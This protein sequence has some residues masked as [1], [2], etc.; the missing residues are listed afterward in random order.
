MFSTPYCPEGNGAVERVNYTIGKLLAHLH[1]AEIDWDILLSKAVIT[2]NSTYH[3]QIKTSPS[4][5]ILAH[6]HDVPE[7]TI[8]GTIEKWT[9]GHTKYCSFK[10]H[11]LVAREKPRSGH[12]VAAKFQSLYEDPY[13]VIAVN[14]NNVTYKLQHCATEVVIRAHHDQLKLWRTAPPYLQKHPYFKLLQPCKSILNESDAA[15]ADHGYVQTDSAESSGESTTSLE[16]S[17]IDW[18]FTDSELEEEQPQAVAANPL[19][20]FSGFQESYSFRGFNV[21]QSA[22]PISKVKPCAACIL[23]S[24]WC[25]RKD[26]D[27]VVSLPNVTKTG[28]ILD[29]GGE[30]WEFSAVQGGS[31]LDPLPIVGD[32]SPAHASPNVAQSTTSPLAANILQPLDRDHSSNADVELA[33]DQLNLEAAFPRQAA[34]AQPVEVE[35]AQAAVEQSIRT[36]EHFI[37]SYYADYTSS[38]KGFT[39]TGT[40]IVRGKTDK[41][42]NVLRREVHQLRLQERAAKLNEL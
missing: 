11:Q 6:S 20:D 21:S 35:N 29:R 5:F 33:A 2:Y 1:A 26:D 9:A 12:L 13:E 8:R 19:L 25:N 38:F 16:R 41:A 22:T 39:P 7:S 30:T 36:L 3:T 28:V 18:M 42:T 37:E 27:K 40:C 32:T 31:I 23:E 4:Q 10:L 24:H 34:E 15:A 14:P 17:S